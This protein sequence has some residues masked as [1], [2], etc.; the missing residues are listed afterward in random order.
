[1]TILLALAVSLVAMDD[2]QKNN[3]A[4]VDSRKEKLREL[5]NE[6]IGWYQVRRSADTDVAMKPLVIMRWPNS[7]RGS[8]DG[9]TVIWTHRGRPE[10]VAAIYPWEDKFV[11]EFDS[12][13]RG[14]FV[15]T[16]DDKVV[17]SPAKAGME[18]RTHDDWPEPGPTRAIRLRQMKTLA[19]QF[20]AT[21]LGWKKDESQKE[22]LRMTPRPLYRYDIQDPQEILDGAL[23]AFVTGTDPEIILVIEATKGGI[24]AKWQYAF[25]RRSSGKL[26]ARLR[27]KMVWEVDRFPPNK[28]QESTHRQ[29]A[30][31]LK[32]VLLLEN[33]D[34]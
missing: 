10:A 32:E 15:M 8:A 30:Q 28:V 16:R 34:Q 14:K 3:S 33:A 1:M 29:F 9:A 31:P 21:L 12:M 5:I 20:S 26:Q 27:G 11:L 2:R 7:I 6:S 18:F 13:S 19:L 25:V 22:E 24:D 17:W 4:Q 23:F